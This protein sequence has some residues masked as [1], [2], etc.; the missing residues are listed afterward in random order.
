MKR[1]VADGFT[2]HLNFTPDKLGTYP[3][4]C[5]ELC[6]IGHSTMRSNLRIVSQPAFAAWVAAKKRAGNSKTA[7]AIAGNS[8]V[9]PNAGN[10]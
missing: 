4:V 7:G 6:G 2:T 9:D 1:D 10:K 8:Y 3:I 5:T